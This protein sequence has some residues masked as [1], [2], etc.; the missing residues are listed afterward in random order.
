LNVVL[1]QLVA[2]SG[3]LEVPS[4][5]PENSLASL[6]EFLSASLIQENAGALPIE[7]DSTVDAALNEAAAKGAVLAAKF[8][9]TATRVRVIRDS[10]VTPA[11][12]PDRPTQVFGPFVDADGSLAQFPVFESARFLT[13]HVAGPVPAGHRSADA[14]S[15]RIFQ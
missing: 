1:D 9:E 15:G 13:A 8:A 5:V 14:P 10:Y 3:R 7:P 4:G 6:R 2:I 11:V 12:T